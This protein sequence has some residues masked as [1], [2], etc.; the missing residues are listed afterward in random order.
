MCVTI[1]NSRAR[2]TTT[3]SGS[4]PSAPPPRGH[5]I[6]LAVER[7]QGLVA[8]VQCNPRPYHTI[9]RNSSQHRS[10]ELNEEFEERVWSEAYKRGSEERI[11]ER[12]QNEDLQRSFEERPRGKDLQKLIGLKGRQWNQSMATRA[13]NCFSTQEILFEQTRHAFTNPSW[14]RAC[15]VAHQKATPSYLPAR[16]LGHP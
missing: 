8:T 9:G 13:E 12:I 1:S 7:R 6:A 11:E 15:L 5:L 4:L 10:T 3:G 14:H 2:R 16:R